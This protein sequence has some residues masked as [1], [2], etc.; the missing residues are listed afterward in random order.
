MRSIP[1][2]SANRSSGSMGV[3]NAF[4]ERGQQVALGDVALA[5]GVTYGPGRRCVAACPSCE[6]V[7]TVD[8]DRHLAAQ[9]PEHVRCL[10][11]EPALA[12]HITSRHSSSATTPSVA[13]TGRVISHARP[14][15]RTTDQCTWCQR[16]RP[17]PI[18]TTD[19]ATTCVVETGAP[20]AR[21]RRSHRPTRS[22]WLGLPL[23]GCGRYGG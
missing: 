19:D 3:T 4:P 13:D 14:M 23:G 2:E 15:L 21:T 12:G 22:G 16:R 17:T 7:H 5:L 11:Q 1:R 8:R 20:A 6:R 18:P 9:H 10:G